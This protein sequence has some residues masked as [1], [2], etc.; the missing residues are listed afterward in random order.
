M[1]KYSDYAERKVTDMG[2]KEASGR[3]VIDM[4]GQVINGVEVI[5]RSGG[6]HA[7]AYWLCKCPRCGKEFSARGTALRA[8]QISSCGCGTPF[9]RAGRTKKASALP[10]SVVKQIKYGCSLCVEKCA[11]DSPCKYADI[12]DNYPDYNAYDKEAKKLFESLG[13]DE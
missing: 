2:C 9:H 10:P 3:R 4:T 5:A 8:G 1:H 6:T 7:G 13:L 12:L 11:L